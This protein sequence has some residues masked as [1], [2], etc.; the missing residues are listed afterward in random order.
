MKD[1]EVKPGQLW[2]SDESGDEWLVTRTY[3]D[4]FDSYAV[5]RKANSDSND[6]R[7]VKVEHSSREHTLP[8]FTRVEG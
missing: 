3:A 7:R 8:G 4:G 2:R 6:S 5:L 1:V